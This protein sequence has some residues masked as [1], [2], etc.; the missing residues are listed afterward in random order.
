[1]IRGTTD[2]LKFKLPYTKNDLEWITIQVSQPGNPSRLLPV[3]KTKTQCSCED[4]STDLYVSLTAEETARFSDKYKAQVTFR[5]KH[6]TNGKIFGKPPQ[7]ITVYPMSDDILEVN[8]LMPDA[9][10]S[11]WIILDGETILTQ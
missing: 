5:A 6:A 8:P 11:G 9:N 4:G 7:L 3:T 2:L 10:E 1:M